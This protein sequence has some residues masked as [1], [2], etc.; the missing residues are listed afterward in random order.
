MAEL[1]LLR[2][3]DE[4]PYLFIWRLDDFLLP[5]VTTALGFVAGAPVSFGLGGFVLDAQ[6]R[7]QIGLAQAEGFVEEAAGLACQGG[8]AFGSSQLGARGIDAGDRSVSLRLKSGSIERELGLC[9][10]RVGPSRRHAAVLARAGAERDP[11]AQ[12]DGL[13]VALADRVAL[14]RG[15]QCQFGICA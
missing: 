1:P 13:A 9:L 3:V 14:T 2:S 15:G 12:C 5:A 11:K 6:A 4:L 10:R 8:A 7:R